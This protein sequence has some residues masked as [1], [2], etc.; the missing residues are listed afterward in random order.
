M[1]DGSSALE[2]ANGKDCPK[3]SDHGA[4]ANFL[5]ARYVHMSMSCYLVRYLRSFQTRG[6]SLRMECRWQSSVKSRLVTGATAV[7]VFPNTG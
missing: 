6:A 3:N 7:N 5:L 4:L 1:G 2:D